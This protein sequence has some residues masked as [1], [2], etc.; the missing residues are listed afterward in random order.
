MS[1][2]KVPPAFGR[3]TRMA[4]AS[5]TFS[6]FVMGTSTVAMVG[7]LGF[8]ADGMSVSHEAVARLLAVFAITFAVAAPGIQVFLGHVRRRTLILCGLGV[9]AFGSVLS[10]AAPNYQVLFGAR[11][12]T[13]LGSAAIG[14]VASALG[15]GLVAREHQG[16]ALAAVLL[17]MTMASVLSAPLANWFAGQAGWRLMFDAI[18]ALNTLAALAVLTQVRD[19]SAGERMSCSA[20]LNVLRQPELAAAIG[21]ALLQMAGV[22]VSYTLVVPVLRDHFGLAD[23]LVPA[24]LMTFGVAGIGGNFVARYLSYRWSADRSVVMALLGMG[25]VFAVL[26]AA[27]RMTAAAFGVMALWAIANDLF[28]PAQ[29]RRLV[30]LAPEM[31]GLVL[32]LN[33]SALYVG[34][35]AGSFAGGR[36]ASRA[37]LALLPVGSML[38]IGGALCALLVSR[39][40]VARSSDT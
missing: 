11:I 10:A 38:F 6:Y 18:A 4:L 30:E 2:T 34:M 28:V 19:R 7:T 16:R 3:R 27:P 21:V 23:H 1:Q 5:L 40:F 9:A 36:L 25:L 17:G 8:I 14:P 37:G 15:A 12:L 20:L 33:A 31:R 39:R 29:Q 32:A 24:A 22:F 13:A 26:Y 35:S